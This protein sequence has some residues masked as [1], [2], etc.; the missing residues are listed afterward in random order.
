MGGV[1]SGAQTPWPR[2][3][4]ARP[5]LLGRCGAGADCACGAL[6]SDRASARH[7]AGSPARTGL[8][9]PPASRANLTWNAW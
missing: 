7:E 6:R 2:I 5:A 8:V 1:R 4:S 9:W 3:R